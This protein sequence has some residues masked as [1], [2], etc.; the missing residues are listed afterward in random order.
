MHHPFNE[1]HFLQE[2]CGKDTQGLYLKDKFRHSKLQLLKVTVERDP[3]QIFYFHLVIKIELQLEQQ[4]A[5]MQGGNIIGKLAVL[6]R[7][8]SSK[9]I[10]DRPQEPN[11]S[12]LY[13]RRGY[14]G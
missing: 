2:F 5:I 1:S 7:L 13:D 12:I 6:S 10:P 8:I 3:V 11:P 4:Q 9:A 14:H